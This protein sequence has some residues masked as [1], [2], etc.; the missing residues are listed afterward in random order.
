M[1]E[2]MLLPQGFRTAGV[3]CGIKAD[4][5]NFDLALFATDGPSTA[6]GVFTQNRVCGAPVKVSR[7]RVPRATVRAVV[8][9]SGNANACTGELGLE[10]ARWMT[11]AVAERLGCAAD[12]V[13]VC[14]TGMI[15][16]FL[17]REKLEAGIPQVADQLADT[18]EA[19]ANAARGMMTTDT[20]QKQ[21]VRQTELGGKTV[22]VSGAAKGA[23]MIAPNMATMLA[24]VMTDA[25]LSPEEA[26]GMLRDVVDRSFNCINVEGHTS[27]SDSVILLASGATENGPLDDDGRQRL[28]SMLNEVTEELAMSIIR[29]A[30]GAGH[31]ITVDV[32]GLA[33]R[34]DAHCIAR[35][36]ADD[37]LVKTAITGNDPNWGRIVSACGRTGVELGEEHITLRINGTLIYQSGAPV[38][39]DEAAVS[40][41]MRDNRDVHIELDLT[42]GEQSARFWTCDL[43]QEYVR[44]NSELTT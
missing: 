22:T 9:N 7:E 19:F 44:L 26:D 43:T 16:H 11:A 12:D 32:R 36:V 31:F 13:L 3:H 34:A 6:V 5:E 42:L 29:D 41:F 39:Y 30:E 8:I 33:T 2:D 23:A 37:V 21:S 40:D 28:Q 38:E 1:A 15:G 17:P 24:V 18:P 20:F 27:T 14:S 35:T 25:V 10:D 4:A